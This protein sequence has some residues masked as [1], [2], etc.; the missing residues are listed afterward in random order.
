MAN[1]SA[2]ILVG[3]GGV[4]TDF[5]KDLLQELKRLESARLAKKSLEMSEREAELDRKIR[6]WPRT[7][8]TDP[9]KTG[10]ENLAESLSNQIDE[11]LVVAY[12]EFCAPSLEEAIDALA[13]EG[14]KSIFI[15]TTM[16]TPGG[17]HSEIEIPQIVESKKR[18][19]AGV[20][21]EY[22]WPYDLDGVAG[23]LSLHLEKSRG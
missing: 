11:D 1:A 14:R 15:L 17:S 2:V 3:H 20:K 16:F 19:H 12:N 7:F 22:L 5:P 4:P 18:Q 10:L 6:Y 9:Y 23:L 21:I 13:A 8:E